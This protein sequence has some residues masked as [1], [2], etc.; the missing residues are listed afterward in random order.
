MVRYLVTREQS[1]SKTSKTVLTLFG[2]GVFAI[3]GF[4][5]RAVRS[6]GTGLGILGPEAL[7]AAP[8][9]ID[10]V[11]DSDGDLLPDALEWVLLTDS[12]SKDTD[13][14]GTDDF[15]EVVEQRSPVTKDEDT[16][17][18]VD[19]FRTLFMTS[20]EGEDQHR[21]LWLHLLFRFP[22]GQLSD[23]TGL[24]LFFDYDGHKVDLTPLLYTCTQALET[25]FETRQGL[26]VRLTLKL[27]EPAGLSK[28]MPA[29]FGSY[30]RIN[31]A[32]HTAGVPMFHLGGSYHTLAMVSATQMILQAASS[33]EVQSTF[34]NKGKACAMS[35]SLV[36]SSPGWRICEVEKADC[37][38]VFQG[39]CSDSCKKS[40][41]Q[42][43]LVPDGTP[44]I[45][46]G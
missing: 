27:P 22:S 1:S 14:D 33:G 9:T 13:S 44:L 10:P 36:G 16:P 45:E 18:P 43:V 3:L 32:F 7:H 5:R 4:D 41:G 35:L 25:R 31:N 30:A 17:L 11:K 19:S 28:L 40:V 42:M 21:V 38:V 12:M 2:L 46:G 34:W 29:T 24:S 6:E 8:E 39:A 20:F 15:V 37:E 23:L 26:L